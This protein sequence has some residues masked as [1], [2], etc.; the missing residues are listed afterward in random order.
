MRSFRGTLY[1]LA[2]LWLGWPS[3]VFCQ[4]LVFRV[5]YFNY[6]DSA[7]GAQYAIGNVDG[8]PWPGPKACAFDRGVGH[9]QDCIAAADGNGFLVY[10]TDQVYRKDEVDGLL[11]SI[12]HDTNTQLESAKTSITG[13]L[14]KSLDQIP[15]RL[16]SDSAKEEIKAAVLLDVKGQLDQLRADLQKQID[17]LKNQVN[18][19]QMAR[20]N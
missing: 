19:S 16:L 20:P 9:K 10:R 14:G 8:H 4:E 17:D 7:G 11:T 5:G 6:N 2:A 1:L 15:Q 3:H 13:S 12:R 18:G